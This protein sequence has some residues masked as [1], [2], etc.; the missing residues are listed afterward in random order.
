[1][2]TALLKLDSKGI[3]YKLAITALFGA[4]AYIATMI[5]QIPTPTEGYVNLG[6]C[7]VILSGWMLGPL[8]GGIA[9][10]VGSMLADVVSGY[11]FYAPAT[12]V[13]K[14]TMAVVAFYVSTLLTSKV[15]IPARISGGLSAVASEVVMITGYFLFEALF[16]GTGLAAAIGIPA[17]A[18]QGL[19]A[20]V[21][22]T[23]LKSV[24]P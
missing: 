2:N 10:G 8:Y 13:I 19:V 12:L 20:I 17:N 22:V 18:V 5:I 1:M 3:S 21:I 14:F 6:D 24:K 7:I 4:L 15:R 23:I 9:A 11:V 16:T